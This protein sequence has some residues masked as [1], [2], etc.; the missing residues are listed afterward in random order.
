[1]CLKQASTFKGIRTNTLRCVQDG[2]HLHLFKYKAQRMCAGCGSN[3]RSTNLGSCRAQCALCMLAWHD[4]CGEA[5]SSHC[6]SDARLATHVSA[7][8]AAIRQ[9]PS[10]ARSFLLTSS[11]DEAAASSSSSSRPATIQEMRQGVCVATLRE[12]CCCSFW[13][14]VTP[15]LVSFCCIMMWGGVGE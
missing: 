6:A 13:Q 3:S 4:S 11:M 15:I 10:W 1:M 5:F 14:S 2:M 7:A 8:T 9:L 12:C